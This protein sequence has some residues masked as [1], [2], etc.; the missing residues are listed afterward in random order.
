MKSLNRLDEINLIEQIP[1]DLSNEFWH[2][3]L[4][5]PIGNT[6]INNRSY[7]RDYVYYH[8]NL[9]LT[10][11]QTTKL[12]NSYRKYHQNQDINLPNRLIQ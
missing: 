9:P 4:Y 11:T 10:A 8:L 7:A 1:D 6:I 2:N 5:N 3:V 12:L